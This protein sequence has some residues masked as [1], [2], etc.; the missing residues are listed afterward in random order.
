VWW[1]RQDILEFQASLGYIAYL[2]KQT[3]TTTTTKKKEKERK[4]KIM[5]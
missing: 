3:N 1:L 5:R 4:K 2:T